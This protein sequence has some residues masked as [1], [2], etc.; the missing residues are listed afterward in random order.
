MK[1]DEK[2]SLG[3]IR[4]K[5]GCSGGNPNDLLVGAQLNAAAAR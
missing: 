5:K 4:I 2:G 1:I 3:V